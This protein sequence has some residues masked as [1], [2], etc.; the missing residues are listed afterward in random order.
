M[1]PYGN[2]QRHRDHPQCM[3][4]TY[5]HQVLTLINGIGAVRV[6]TDLQQKS[7]VM[8]LWIDTGYELK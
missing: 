6:R 7:R 2:I 5:S 4:S 8:K 1:Y 3:S